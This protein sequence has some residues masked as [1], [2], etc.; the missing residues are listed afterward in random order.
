MFTLSRLR[1]DLYDRRVVE[2]IYDPTVICEAT[3][4]SFL[5]TEDTL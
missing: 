2:S 5:A 4:I 1:R 3:T